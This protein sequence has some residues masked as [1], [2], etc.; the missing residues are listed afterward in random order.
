MLIRK[1]LRILE[2]KVIKLYDT[3]YIRA[4]SC[5]IHGE[6]EGYGSGCVDGVEKEDAEREGLKLREFSSGEA[7]C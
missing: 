2:V 1:Y 5:N 6:S 4:L 3:A 7:G